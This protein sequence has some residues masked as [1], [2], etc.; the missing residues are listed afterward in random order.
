MNVPIYLSRIVDYHNN[1]YWLDYASIS[2]VSGQT[3]AEMESFST[4][5]DADNRFK[6]IEDMIESVRYVYG[7]KTNLWHAVLPH[8]R[9]Y[10]NGFTGDE[11]KNIGSEKAKEQYLSNCTI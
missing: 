3:I 8:D 2:D 5:Q 1:K 7:T 4:S 10:N 9:D 11:I 6:D